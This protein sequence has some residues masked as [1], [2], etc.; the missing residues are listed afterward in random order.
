VL[1]V[2]CPFC[3]SMLESTPGKGPDPLA[4]RDVA[5]LL[6]E[7][8]QRASKNMN[9]LSIQATLPLPADNP[10]FS[11]DESRTHGVDVQP[12][13]D[14]VGE[15]VLS[16]DSAPQT[17]APP[18]QSAND[19]RDIEIASITQAPDRRKPWTPKRKVDS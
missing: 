6:L 8:V 18:M 7:G 14:T 17:P 5:E 3:K 19:E 13:S 15:V 12:I 4:I 2:G 10:T 11:P 16:T 9:P 1:A